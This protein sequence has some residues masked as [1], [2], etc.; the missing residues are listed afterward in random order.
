MDPL[1]IALATVTLATAVKDLGEILQKLEQ[2]FSKPAENVRNAEMLTT[3]VRQTLDR[4]KRFCDEQEEILSSANDMK[5]ALSELIR[6]MESV[7]DKCSGIRPVTAKK[8]FYKFKATFGAWKNRNKVQSEIKELVNRVNRC[9]TQ[10][11]MFSMMRI[12]KRLVISSDTRTQTSNIIRNE[13]STTVSDERIIGFI[14]SNSATLSKLPPEIQM[15]SDIISNAYLRLQIDAINELM[16]KLSSTASYPV[17]EPMGDYLLPFQAS[18]AF[19]VVKSNQFILRRDLI[20]QALQIQTILEEDSTS[21]SVQVGAGALDSLASNLLDL[22]MYHES[23]LIG[24]WAVK[25]YRTLVINHPTTYLPHLALSIANLAF[26]HQG[27]DDDVNGA[28]PLISECIDIGRSLQTPSASLD[29][30]LILPYVLSISASM[31]SFEKDSLK[32]LEEAEEAIR[33]FDNVVASSN[34]TN[35][36]L[37]IARKSVDDLD[38]SSNF[39]AQHYAQALHQLSPSSA[40]YYYAEALQRFSASLQ[41]VGQFAEAFQAQQSALKIL[42][43]LVPFHPDRL[44]LDRA[45]ALYH[46]LEDD[47]RGFLLPTDALPMSQESISIFRKYFE[48]DRQQYGVELC[49][50]LWQ[51]AALLE[52]MGQYDKALLV[53]K[54][55]TYLV[56]EVDEDRLP[57]TSALAKFSSA[58]R[59]L[60]RHD[61]AA[62][63]RRKLLEAYSH[64][65]L[66][67]DLQL[68]GQYPEAIHEAQ[69]SVMQYRT[70]AFQEPGQNKKD[71]AQ[72]LHLLSCILFNANEYKKAFSQGHEACDLYQS[73]IQDDPSILSDYVE[74]IRLHIQISEFSDNETESIERGE[75]LIRYSNKLIKIFPDE[76]ERTLIYVTLIHSRKLNRFDRLTEATVT[77]QE[78]LDW[79]ESVPADTPS[80]V[81]LHRQCL[82]QMAIVL[83]AQGYPEPEKALDTFE[84]A[85]NAGKKFTSDP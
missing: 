31:T 12:E 59:L 64:H 3:Q 11:M 40:V 48:K 14:G 20:T 58:L 68:A 73:V 25:L 29:I 16:E 24:A 75:S 78:A 17:E 37:Q 61:E 63:S 67:Y 47:F 82:R 22:D 65:N 83:L 60:E 57:L 84:E 34:F 23:A 33:F 41:K 39:A 15:S 7:Y 53:W 74:C 54:E 19:L 56:Q 38:N 30:K 80:A 13:I 50:V 52:K 46:V 5:V 2:S 49:D 70:L 1:S 81:V 26:A 43:F 76:R 10:F 77:I 71:L 45:R 6:D 51:N 32:S 42:D 79:Y 35:G 27:I 18:P 69:T 21:L 62:N 85:I 4:L 36:E 9:Y 72:G 55:V 28:L 66:A 8:K 44:D